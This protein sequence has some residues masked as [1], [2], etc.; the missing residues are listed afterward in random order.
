MF[1]AA[2]KAGDFANQQVEVPSKKVLGR[3]E[4]GG[5]IGDSPPVLAHFQVTSAADGLGCPAFGSLSKVQRANKPRTV[6]P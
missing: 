4:S 6:R 2:I 5:F 3:V 1:G